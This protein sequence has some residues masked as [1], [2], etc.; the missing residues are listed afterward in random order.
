MIEKI[1]E[2]ENINLPSWD[3]LP[4]DG[5]YKEELLRYLNEI[6]SPLHV[7]EKNLISSSMVNN[8]VKLGYIDRPEK[9][10]YYRSSIA[11][12]VVISIF[13]QVIS[14]EDLAKG[15]DIE[16]STFGLKDV[17]EN[18]EN[19]FNQARKAILTSEKVNAV[20]ISFEYTDHH[21][22]VLSYL[23]IS[24][25]TKLYTQLVIDNRKEI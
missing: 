22:K 12:L 2:L 14:I 17:Y 20:N 23:A 24:L 25:F 9:K 18:F 4:N 6:L 1:N 13:K 15:I 5:I 10:K 8:Y 19:I 16:M 3:S 7:V 11:Q 21:D